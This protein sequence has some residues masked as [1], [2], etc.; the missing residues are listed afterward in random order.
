[1]VRYSAMTAKNGFI[2]LTL[3]NCNYC[4]KDFNDNEIHRVRIDDSLACKK[5]Y[6]MMK[7]GFCYHGQ[8]KLW[9]GKGELI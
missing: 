3:I 5:C 2:L 4:H 6:Q 8:L 7:E 1:M 9:E